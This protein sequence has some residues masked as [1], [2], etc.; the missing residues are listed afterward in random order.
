MSVLGLQ[1]RHL[2]K[3]KAATGVIVDHAACLHE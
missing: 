2:V 3:P 1:A